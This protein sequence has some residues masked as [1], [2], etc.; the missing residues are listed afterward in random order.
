MS[1]AWSPE[2]L[3]RIEHAE[4]L[5]IAVKRPDG[6]TRR[7]V[8]VWVVCAGDQVY[9][10]TWHRR[11]GGWFGHVLESRQARIHVADLE[12]DVT[13]EDVG[14]DKPELRVGVD[15]AYRAKYGHYGAGSVDRMVTDDAAAA[16]LRL[17][18]KHAG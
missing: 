18:A 5:E 6:T 12:A 9:V 13:V 7:P 14:A 15:A 10:R 11:N 16:T 8:P 17:V 3:K 2:Q 4:E 1:A